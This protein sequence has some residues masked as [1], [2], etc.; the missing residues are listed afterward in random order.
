MP[1]TQWPQD[2]E[3][4]AAIME[5]WTAATGD[6][7]QELVFI[8]QNVDFPRLTADL[9]ECLLSDDEMAL[10]VQGWRLMADPFGPW[11]DEE[12]A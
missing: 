11:F 3:S 4:T 5:N 7:R 10:G 8:G 9:D 1:K 6:C 2:Q 12:A